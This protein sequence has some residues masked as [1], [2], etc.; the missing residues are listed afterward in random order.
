MNNMDYLMQEC[1]MD[2]YNAEE[3]SRRVNEFDNKPLGMAYVPWQRWNGAYNANQ[4]IE[5][6]TIF[7]DLE[8]PFYGERGACGMRGDEPWM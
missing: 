1:P 8:L 2:D 3:Y 7:P 5:A 4:G 6:G